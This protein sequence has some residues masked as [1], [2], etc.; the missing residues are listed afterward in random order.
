MLLPCLICGKK[1]DPA[2]SNDK[3]N[4]Q[5]ADGTA[6]ASYGHYGSTVWDPQ[7]GTRVRLEITICDLCLIASKERTQVAVQTVKYIQEYRE[8]N[9]S[10]DY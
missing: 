8:W 3:E 5:P 9:P 2:I 10:L 7:M 1:L 4:N 6:F